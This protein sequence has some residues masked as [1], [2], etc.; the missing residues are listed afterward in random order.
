M[1]MQG[2]FKFP[3]FF[4]IILVFTFRFHCRF[5]RDLITLLLEDNIIYRTGK[6]YRT[7]KTFLL[8]KTTNITAI[9]A[10]VVLV[11]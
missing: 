6:N 5:V 4:K 1:L 8:N 10:G 11:A 3:L 7:Q 2:N 9:N